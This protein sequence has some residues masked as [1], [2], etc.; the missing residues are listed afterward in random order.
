MG[1]VVSCVENGPSHDV[2]RA[3]KEGDHALI[4]RRVH[5]DPGLL[6]HHTFN[7]KDTCWHMA[8]EVGNRDTLAL[9]LTLAEQEGVVAQLGGARQVL[10]QRNAKG[11]TPLHLACWKDH[12][13]CVKWLLRQGGDIHAVDRIGKRVAIHYAAMGGSPETIDA[14]LASMP[15]RE[16]IRYLDTR[17]QSGFTP[18]HFAAA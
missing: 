6:T 16:A 13:D 18:L 9:L 7:D 10:N 12:L 8:A 3:C 14:L 4:T 15:A 11:L 1:A 17:T 5:M 2:G